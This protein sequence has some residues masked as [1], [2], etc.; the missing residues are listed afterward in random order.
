MSGDLGSNFPHKCEFGTEKIIFW[1]NVITPEGIQPE[2]EKIHTFLANLKMPTTVRQVKRLIGF[3]QF[4]RNF[5]PNLNEKLLPFYKLLRRD[6]HFET[7]NSH[8]TALK[9][10]EDDLL[11]A[12]KM[13]LT[14]AKPDS[15]YVILTDASYHQAG[16]VLMI[17]DYLK[18]S[19]DNNEHK[20]YAPV[21]FGSKLFNSA[22]L[23]LSIYCKE[24][25]AVAFAL[26]HFSQFVWGAQKPVLVLTDNKSLTRFFQSKTIPPSLWNSLDRVLAFNIVVGHI[27]GK[28]N[29]AADFLS[30]MENDPTETIEL[31]LT[32]RI[33]VYEIEISS[34]AKTPDVSLNTLAEFSREQEAEDVNQLQTST[35]STA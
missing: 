29:A 12:T 15:Q 33:P 22:Q 1:G 8:E 16:F 2:S 21:S 14:L 5:L 28:A 32:D 20:I 7:D 3:Y 23:K 17:E 6:V 18:A 24:F 13:T 34:K 25:L 27:P 4:F 10:L 9:T 30:R 35:L 26:E 19:N 11:A 31:T